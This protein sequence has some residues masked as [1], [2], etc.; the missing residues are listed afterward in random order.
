MDSTGELMLI[1]RSPE[2]PPPL[3]EIGSTGEAILMS[4]IVLTP[5]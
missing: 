2:A 3:I 4:A 5:L 1:A